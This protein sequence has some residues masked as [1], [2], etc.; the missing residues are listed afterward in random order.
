MTESCGGSH[1]SAKS[2]TLLL[3]LESPFALAI[4]T[5]SESSQRFI[6]PCI[7]GV[8]CLFVSVSGNIRLSSV[9]NKMSTDRTLGIASFINLGAN[10]QGQAI[11]GDD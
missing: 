1:N 9:Q 7:T 4:R 5:I 3:R 6:P 8:S 11:L 10:M 2:L